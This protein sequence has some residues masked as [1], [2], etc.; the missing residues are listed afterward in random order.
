MDKI[1]K[2]LADIN[3]RKILTLLKNDDSNVSNI[4]KKLDIGQPTVS[5]HLAVLRKA[6]LVE[7]TVKSKERIYKLKREVFNSFI[8]QLNSFMSDEIIIRRIN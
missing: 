3:R 7:V 4:V 1:F 8:K 2:A 5:S 6:G